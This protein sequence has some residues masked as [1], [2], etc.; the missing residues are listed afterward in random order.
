MPGSNSS[1]GTE[2]IRRAA[3]VGEPCFHCL[4]TGWV[5]LTAEN[6]YG[7]LEDYFSCSAASARSV[8]NVLGAAHVLLEEGTG[9]GK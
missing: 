3:P 9:G 4:N 1:G 6:D 5:M 7:E 2:Q 8:V